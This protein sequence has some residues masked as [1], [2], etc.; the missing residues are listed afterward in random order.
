MFPFNLKENGDMDFKTINVGNGILKT[1]IDGKMKFGDFSQIDGPFPTFPGCIYTRESGSNQIEVITFVVHGLKKGTTVFFANSSGGLDNKSYVV[2]AI[3]SQTRFIVLGVG[4]EPINGSVDVF[5]NSVSVQI[6]D[7]EGDLKNRDS[8]LLIYA[9]NSYPPADIRNNDGSIALSNNKRISRLPYTISNSVMTITLENHGFQTGDI[10]MIKHPIIRTENGIITR[11]NNNMFSLIV[12]YDS[13]ISGFDMAIDDGCSIIFG[14]TNSNSVC[15][16]HSRIKATP[17]SFEIECYRPAN[18]DVLCTYQQNKYEGGVIIRRGSSTVLRNTGFNVDILALTFSGNEFVGLYNEFVYLTVDGINWIQRK[19][20]TEP[21]VWE[22]IIYVNNMYIGVSDIIVVSSNTISWNI[23]NSP[24]LEY[25]GVSFGMGIYVAVGVMGISTSLDGMNWTERPQSINKSYISIIFGNNRFVASTT[26][27]LM[28]SNNGT[29]WSSSN[30]SSGEY[31]GVSFGNGVYVAV[32]PSGIIQVSTNGIIWDSQQVVSLPSSFLPSSDYIYNNIIFGENIFIA[33]TSSG[34]RISIDGLIWEDKLFVNVSTPFF[35]ISFGNSTVIVTGVDGIV[36][37]FKT[38]LMNTIS[39]FVPNTDISFP[40]GSDKLYLDVFTGKADTGVYNIAQ[41]IEES[42]FKEILIYGSDDIQPE[43]KLG[44]ASIS[45][46]HKYSRVLGTYTISLN[47]I[48]PTEYNEI[49]IGDYIYVSFIDKSDTIPKSSTYIVKNIYSNSITFEGE[50]GISVFNKDCIILRGG[51]QSRFNLLPDGRVGFNLIPSGKRGLDISGDIKIGGGLY[52][53]NNIQYNPKTHNTSGDFIL[54]EEG[55]PI[56]IFSPNDEQSDTW[57]YTLENTTNSLIDSSRKSVITSCSVDNTNNVCITGSIIVGQF[58]NAGLFKNG[59]FQDRVGVNPA[60]PSANIDRERGVI[61]KTDRNGNMLWSLMIY[62]N[63]GDVIVSSS[64]DKITGRVYIIVKSNSDEYIINGPHLQHP[65]IYT[66]A[67]NTILILVETNGNVTRMIKFESDDEVFPMGLD[68]SSEGH[69]TVAIAGDRIINIKSQFNDQLSKIRPQIFVGGI[70]ISVIKISIDLLSVLAEAIFSTGIT[71]V[72]DLGFIDQGLSASRIKEGIV[73]YDNN[74]EGNV[75]YL[76]FPAKIT[77]GR[78]YYYDGNIPMER[79][80]A[81]FNGSM[82]VGIINNYRLDDIILL[83]SIRQG[84]SETGSVITTS[85]DVDKGPRGDSRNVGVYICGTCDG[86]IAFI[87]LIKFGFTFIQGDITGT[88][89]SERRGAFLC[90]IVTNGSLDWFTM[91]DG[92][93]DEQSVSLSVSSDIQSDVRGSYGIYLL[94]SFK[95][96]TANIFDSRKGTLNNADTS[97]IPATRLIKSLANGNGNQRECYILKFD[98]DGRYLLT[99]KTSTSENLTPIYIDVGLGD[100][101]I[102]CYKT[103]I[104]DVLFKEPDG[105][106]SR[107]IKRQFPYSIGVILKYRTTNSLVLVPPSS[108]F[109][110]LRK[111]IVNKSEFSLYIEAY[112][113]GNGSG[114][115]F[116]NVFVIPSNSISNLNYIDSEWYSSAS[117]SLSSDLLSLDTDNGK[118]GIGVESPNVTFDIAGDI[119]IDGLATFGSLNLPLSSGFVQNNLK[120]SSSGQIST[121]NSSDF[122]VNG[123]QLIP[124]GTILMWFSGIDN[125]PPPGWALCDGQTVNG[126]QIPDLRGRFVLGYNQSSFTRP[127]NSYQTLTNSIG[128][129]SGEHVSQLQVENLPAHNHVIPYRGAGIFFAASNNRGGTGSF[130]YYSDST[131]DE[132]GNIFHNNMPPYRVI[133]YICKI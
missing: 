74:P 54:G 75:T 6:G 112:R 4:T 126:I 43:R 82:C 106:V 113:R 30:I 76:T 65:I 41:V 48:I 23:T 71:S 12:D 123:K 124:T 1:N 129:V 130:G 96:N 5:V 67:S 50:E 110:K 84:S 45:L 78:M 57:M 58:G 122:L 34:V 35:G 20:F 95:S 3:V 117:E 105:R 111:K 89:I 90:K 68:I 70:K 53:R 7:S 108:S 61:Y 18:R 60:I 77:N 99:F 10:I 56:D 109:S 125:T 83:T 80:L 33:S 103:L 17:N 132:G 120:T 26:S 64:M 8:K 98:Q 85:I 100:N 37:S 29:I 118:I 91:I 36:A 39:V 21:H 9:D 2:N 32:S 51:Y 81:S 79:P 115:V 62:S 13:D 47:K 121:I 15:M 93:D 59:V 22:D 73:R 104:K 38:N 28:F 63:F 31:T 49:G 40:E 11:I 24:N 128:E 102:A 42:T 88:R 46:I 131:A 87:P 116:S 127:G 69:L 27:G 119:N 92:N 133:M 107:S 114:I 16:P 97:I 94:G 55:T 44:N 19:V 66:S 86:A 72:Q 52:V 101:V 25:K 14:S